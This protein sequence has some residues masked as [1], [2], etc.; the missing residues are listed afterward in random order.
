MDCNCAG[1]AQ[2]IDD[3]TRLVGVDS[4]ISPVPEGLSIRA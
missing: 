2:D 1:F 3:A 4:I